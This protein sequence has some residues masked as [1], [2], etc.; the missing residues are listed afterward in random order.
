[1]KYG[2]L[3]VEGAW[4]SRDKTIPTAPYGTA[5]N[6]SNTFT[7]DESWYLDAK[8]AKTIA[9]NTDIV[10]RVYFDDYQFDGRYAYSGSINK[11]TVHGQSYGSEITAS[12][13]FF[14]G[15]HRISAGA[16]FVDNFKQ[17]QRN[18][19]LDPYNLILNSEENEQ[20][21]SYFIQD[22][23]TVTSWLTI[24]GGLCFDYSPNFGSL[25]NPRLAALLKPL[26]GSTVKLIYGRALRPPNAYELYY[27]DGVFTQ[28]PDHLDPERNTSYEALLEQR[29]A[30]NYRMTAGVFSYEV[31]DMI[32]QIED[33]VTGMA[34]FQNAGQM[35]AKG[36]E[37]EIEGTWKANLR[38][39]I[40]YTYQE[41]TDKSTGEWL[42]N[43]PHH[44]GK[45]N[46]IV[47][48]FHDNWSLGTNLQYMSSRKTTA[49]TDTDDVWLLN[50]TLLAKNI[51][52]NVS[53]SLSGYNLLN[54][55][56]KDPVGL[57]FRQSGIEQDGT[58]FFF[59]LIFT[60]Y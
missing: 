9:G 3:S 12:R 48:F 35:T 46:I 37:F 20:K 7:V 17:E 14:D 25:T 45:V 53:L 31:D 54:Q 60:N 58:S 44:I 19:D 11:D 40:G 24:N 29:L 42:V 15:K 6:T 4:V 10:A 18:E 34:V 27:E 57:E 23:Y 21:W 47:P 56:Y 26:E 39:N 50:T 49:G 32:R 13:R 43:S 33:P 36:F 5:F 8:Y 16:E 38:G 52:P 28:R 55:K 51:L 41:A 1:M 2:P 59:K 22:E 30:T